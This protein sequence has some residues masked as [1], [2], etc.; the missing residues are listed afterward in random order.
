MEDSDN[1]TFDFDK[2]NITPIT[3]ARKYVH[4]IVA[5]KNGLTLEYKFDIM[6]EEDAHRIIKDFII[7]QQECPELVF[8][9]GVCE[10]PSCVDLCNPNHYC[11][12][13][14][15]PHRLVSFEYQEEYT[16]IEVYVGTLYKIKIVL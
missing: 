8:Q 14:T 10:K 12:P 3:P 1:I 13:E 9:V 2:I 11:A 7:N 16:Y 5:F 6:N 4:I 15:C